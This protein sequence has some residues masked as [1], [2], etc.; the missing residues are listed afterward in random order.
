MTSSLDYVIAQSCYP[1]S[2]LILDG[3]ASIVSYRQVDTCVH[4]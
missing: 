1:F 4:L 3:F 2:M